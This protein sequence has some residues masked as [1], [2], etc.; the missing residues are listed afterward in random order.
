MAQ[1]T[2]RGLRARSVSQSNPRRFITPGRKPSSTTSASSTR[3]RKTSRPAS[4]FRSSVMLRLLRARNGMPSPN[5]SR[6]AVITSTSI[7]RSASSVEQNGPGSCRERSSILKRPRGGADMRVPR[8]YQSLLGDGQRGRGTR[9]GLGITIL[10]TVDGVVVGMKILA[11]SGSPRVGSSNAALLR[12]AHDLA[13]AGM[14]LSVYDEIGS[15]PMFTPDLDGEGAVPPPAVAAFR[16]LL[17]VADGVIISSPEYAHGVPGALKSALDWIV[18]SGELEGKPVALLFAS[19]SG[20]SWAQASL[21]PTLEVMGARLVVNLT[22]VF[23]RTQIDGDGRLR[24]PALV[25]TVRASLAA[26]AAAIGPAPV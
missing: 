21:T 26:L 18:S 22:L 25:E 19:P 3:R 16:A 23:A 2:S 1:Y 4:V 10:A 5:G 15:L 24:D 8:S 7:P 12:A 13:P 14:E 9:T 17:G 6:G 20:G 11:I